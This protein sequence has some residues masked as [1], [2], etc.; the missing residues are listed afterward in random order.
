[1][2][3]VKDVAE[4]GYKAMIKGD[5]EVISGLALYLKVMN[6]FIPFTPKRLL[7]KIIKKMQE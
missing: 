5:Y 3:D 4:D 1:V 2:A 7:L 6:F